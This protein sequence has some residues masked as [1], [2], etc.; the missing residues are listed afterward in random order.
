MRDGNVLISFVRVFVSLF[1]AFLKQFITCEQY[2][3]VVLSMNDNK[4]AAG[5][6]TV[7]WKGRGVESYRVATK[8]FRTPGDK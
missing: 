4:S 3:G 7:A 2:G 6:F 1:K 5:C 8:I